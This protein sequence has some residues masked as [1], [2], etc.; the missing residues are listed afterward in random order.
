MIKLTAIDAADA[1]PN[2]Y[3]PR[4]EQG[5]DAVETVV[6]LFLNVDSHLFLLLLLHLLL[7]LLLLRYHHSGCTNDGREGKG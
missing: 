3:V 1:D 2:Q 5:D 7:T 4:A 6:G